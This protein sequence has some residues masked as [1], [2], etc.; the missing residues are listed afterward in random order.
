MRTSSSM[1]E[2]PL[3]LPDNQPLSPCETP[4]THRLHQLRAA[5]DAMIRRLFEI[6]TEHERKAH[7]EQIARAR[8]VLLQWI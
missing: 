1:A 5:R 7:E 2:V 6:P 3:Q 4:R 8:R